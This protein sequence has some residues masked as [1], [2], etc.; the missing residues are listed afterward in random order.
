MT[1]EYVVP[2]RGW[3]FPL[4]MLVHGLPAGETIIVPTKRLAESADRIVQTRLGKKFHFVVAQNAMP[5]CSFCN[6]EIGCVACSNCGQQACTE[7][8]TQF[9]N[10]RCAHCSK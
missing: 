3:L 7:C 8:V 4:T 6:K 5:L 2:E 9:V 1:I 10:G